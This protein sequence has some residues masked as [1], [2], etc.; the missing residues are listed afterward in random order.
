MEFTRP[1]TNDATNTVSP[2]E[3]DVRY[4]LAEDGVAV[5][6]GSGQTINMGS[7][8][9]AFAPKDRSPRADLSSYPSVGPCC[10]TKPVPCG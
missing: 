5:S 3:R 4:K 10:W 6:T 7:G 9:V 8:G 2:F 1:E